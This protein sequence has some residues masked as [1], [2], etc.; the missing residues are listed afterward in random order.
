MRIT[1]RVE[2]ACAPR[3]TDTVAM[4]TSPITRRFALLP[5]AG[6]FRIYADRRADRTSAANASTSSGVVFHEHIQRTSP[7]RSSQS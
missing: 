7:V 1:Y 3:R 2:M 5:T 6:G 4:T